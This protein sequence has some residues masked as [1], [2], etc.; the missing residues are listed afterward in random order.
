M[1]RYYGAT[2]LIVLTVVLVLVIRKHSGEIAMLLGLCGCCV[3][4][5][6][7]I[8]FLTPVVSFVRRLQQLTMLDNE[9]LQILLKVTGVSFTSEIAAT[10]CADA[11]NTALAKSLQMLSTVVILY[12]SLPMLQALLDLVEQILGA[13]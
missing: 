6:V 12:L 7:A 10:V 4:F 1:E 8:G 5:A 3:V 9:M 11:G 2:A 13:L